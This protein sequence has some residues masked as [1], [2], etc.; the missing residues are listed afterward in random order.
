L[1]RTGSVSIRTPEGV[2]FALLPAGP[3]ARFVA[4]AID[5]ACVSAVLIPASLVL[6][7]LAQLTADT[8]QAVRIVLFFLVSLGYAM[9]LEWRFKGQTVGKRLLAIRV[10]D[11]AGMSLRPGQIII[12]NLLRVVDSLPL[13]YLVGGVSCFLSG[14]SQRLGDIAAGT[15]VIRE[16]RA[17][18]PDLE[19][20]A[21][22]KYNS[23]REH[24]LLV[25]RLRQRTSP[26]EADIA[27]QACLR[28]AELEPVSRV[29]LFTEIADHFMGS[30]PI[31]GEVAEGLGAEQLVRDV[32]EVLFTPGTG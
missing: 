3:V 13:F 25:A 23:L 10:V 31:P 11:D 1:G 24:R 32:V 6:G 22:G 18:R 8:A 26:R 12:R 2:V 16:S 4:W 14:R 5:L 21:S 29:E 27:L 19:Q 17:A 15:M 20:V 30:I 7:L 9:V 28:R